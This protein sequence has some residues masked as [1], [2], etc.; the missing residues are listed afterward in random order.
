MS[1]IIYNYLDAVYTIDYLKL[2]T[3]EEDMRTGK[4]AV[5]SDVILIPNFDKGWEQLSGLIL[6]IELGFDVTRNNAFWAMHD[7]LT[8]KTYKHVRGGGHEAAS[9][10]LKYLLGWF[11]QMK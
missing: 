1:S 8:T 6:E 11:T 4:A 7:W 5:Q 10:N 9:A 2:E 3:L